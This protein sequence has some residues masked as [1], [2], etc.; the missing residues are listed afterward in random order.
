M[1]TTVRALASSLLLAYQAELEVDM[2]TSPT[3]ALW[4]ELCV[5]TDLCL[6][7][8]RSAVQASGRAMAREKT[9]LL[10]VPVDPK[11][12]FGPAYGVMLKRWEEKKREGEALRLCLPRRAPFP[13]NAPGQVFTRQPHGAGPGQAAGA[14]WCVGEETTRARGGARWSCGPS[15]YSGSHKETACYL[16]GGQGGTAGP[17]RHCR[18][19][20]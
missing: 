5:V 14:Q 18:R 17:A 6:R 12:L 13:T 7:L 16:G 8:H 2:S 15:G 9:Q 11:G 20:P 19:P 1:A 3:P 4:D 10:D